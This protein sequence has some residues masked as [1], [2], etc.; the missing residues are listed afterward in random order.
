MLALP[1]T[2]GATAP[3]TV[4][5]AL[6]AAPA[7]ADWRAAG[8]VEHVFTHFSLTPG[9]SMRQARTVLTRPLIWTPLDEAVAATPSLFAKALRGL[10]GG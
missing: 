1:T 3:W 9:Q 7:P 6:A 4:V 2:A 5:E 10:R 8:E